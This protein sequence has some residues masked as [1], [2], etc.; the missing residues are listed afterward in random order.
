[1]K[2]D[3]SINQSTL[4]LLFNEGFS[5]DK[6]IVKAWFQRKYKAQLFVQPFMGKFIGTVGISGKAYSYLDIN[7]EGYIE[8]D[9]ENSCF[10]ALVKYAFVELNKQDKI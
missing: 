9:D 10:E 4:V 1:M 3:N 5:I 2:K 8:F 7:R 6:T